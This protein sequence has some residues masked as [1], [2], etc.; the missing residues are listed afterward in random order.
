MPCPVAHTVVA[1][2]VTMA[3]LHRKASTNSASS[4]STGGSFLWTWLLC[5]LAATLINV[6]YEAGTTLSKLHSTEFDPVH[7]ELIVETSN[8][9]STEHEKIEPKLDPVKNDDSTESEQQQ[10]Q[11]FQFNQLDEAFRKDKGPLLDL[12]RDAGLEEQMDREKLERLPSWSQI[13]SLYGDKPIIRGLNDGQC[14]RFQKS[15][16]ASW[17]FVST[18]GTFNTGTNLMAELLIANCHMPE[19]EKLPRPFKGAGVRWQVLWGKHT[20]ID[21]EHFRL[22]HRTYNDTNLRAEYMFPAVMV[23]DPYKWM[24]R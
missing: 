20:P 1:S 17:H 5:G 9:Q 12:I 6:F 11:S 22:T 14:E 15:S 3:R 2:T 8:Q 4:N 16:N 24:Q 7:G 21:D 13:T 10:K 19:H 23:R 18:A